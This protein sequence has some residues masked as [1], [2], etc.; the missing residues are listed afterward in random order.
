[1]KS[2]LRFCVNGE[3]LRTK[4]TNNIDNFNRELAFTDLDWL[5]A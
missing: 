5:W 1:M 3:L 4:A 2:Y